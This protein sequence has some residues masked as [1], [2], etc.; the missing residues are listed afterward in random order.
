MKFLKHIAMTFAAATALAS[1]NDYLDVTPPSSV[2]PEMY[3]T[4]AEQLGYYT[5]NYYCNYGNWDANGTGG[6]FPFTRRLHLVHP[7]RRPHR[8]RGRISNIYY[9][10]DDYKV[11]QTGG[12]WNFDRINDL[13]WFIRTVEPR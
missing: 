12:Q 5:V 6:Q 3:F 13:N 1:C 10:G 7:R 8:Q 9:E 2:S 11:G 4:T